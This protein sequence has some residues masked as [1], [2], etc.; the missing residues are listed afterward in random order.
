MRLILAAENA[1]FAHV[2]KLTFFLTNVADRQA[3]NIARQNAF[4]THRPASTLVEISRLII[5]GTLV[6]IEAIAILP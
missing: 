5:P 2:T 3:V 6:E 4:G 1:T